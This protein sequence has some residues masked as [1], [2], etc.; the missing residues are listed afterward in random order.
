MTLNIIQYN[1]ALRVENNSAAA[2]FWDAGLQHKGHVFEAGK[3]YTVSAFMKAEQG[4][5]QPGFPI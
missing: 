5:F 1:Y 3:F 2:N 4:T